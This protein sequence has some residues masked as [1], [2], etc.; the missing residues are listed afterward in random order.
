MRFGFYVSNHASR[1][2]KAIAFLQSLSALSKMLSNIAFVMRDSVLDDRLNAECRNANIT[3]HQLSLDEIER[4]MKS[5]L[6]SDALL[7]L[8]KDNNADYLF[9]FGSRLLKGPLLKH[10]ENKIINFHPS[11]LPA[12]PGVKSIDQAIQYGSSIIGNTAH[13]IDE[14]I[15]TGQIIMQNIAVVKHP[16]DY[17]VILDN[18]IPMLIQLMQWLSD[19]RISVSGRRVLVER[20]SYGFAPFVPNLELQELQSFHG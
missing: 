2:T 4:S 18:Q 3:L 15:D 10:Y 19:N 7:N 6:V 1:L 20:A 11:L 17:D 14:G 9:V 8:M 13:F 5:I 12:F 16:V